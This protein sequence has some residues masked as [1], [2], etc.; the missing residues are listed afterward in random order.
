MKCLPITA[1]TKPKGTENLFKKN[2][3]KPLRG[4]CLRDQKCWYLNETFKKLRLADDFITLGL[5]GSFFA[6]FTHLILNRENVFF[7]YTAV[8]ETVGINAV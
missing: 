3:V 2:S 6:H 4:C 5:P 7:M 1:I 8:V